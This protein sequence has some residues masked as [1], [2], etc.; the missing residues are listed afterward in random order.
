MS[1]DISESD[2]KIPAAL[3][4]VAETLL[5]SLAA[6]A[7]DAASPDP[8][9]G[10]PYAK[11]TLDKL[12]YDAQRARLS[13][14]DAG[15][16]ALRTR[17]LD[18]WTASFLH[19]HPCCTVLHLACGLDSRMQRVGWGS[20]VRW[21]DVDLPE[22]IALRQQI[23]PA[24]FPDRDYLLV[25]A[26]VTDKAWL[27]GIPADRPT[28]IVMEGLLSYLMEE[29]VEILL[30]RLVDRFGEGELLFECINSTV[31]AS[32]QKRNLKSVE[33]TGAAFH[34]AVDDLSKVR[35]LHPNLDLLETI[36][37]HEAPG[38][39]QFPISR[40]LLLYVM[41]WV[42]SLRDSA[43]FVRFGFGPRAVGE[44]RD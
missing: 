11:A 34:W 9:L 2:T 39:H 8:I 16:V 13:L 3:S 6:R 25:G 14:L 7:A 5:I 35:E 1:P 10:D 44:T 38:V 36:C 43:R 26:R 37:F 28:I 33:Q 31:L 15:G 24:S 32:L 42:P 4:G 29:D 17:Q 41:S 12:E 40:R 30:S 18:Q 19:D 21:I 27:E 22:V 23:M 20:D